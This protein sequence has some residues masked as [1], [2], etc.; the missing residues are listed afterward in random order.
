MSYDEKRIVDGVEWS[1]TDP[2]PT[3][4]RRGE[5]GTIYQLDAHDEEYIHW[6]PRQSPCPGCQHD[7]HTGW[8]YCGCLDDRQ[9]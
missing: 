1:V 3:W 6:S 5:D 8:C 7:Q 4:F 9:V 2:Y